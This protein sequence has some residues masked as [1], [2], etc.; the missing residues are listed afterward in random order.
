L[1][2]FYYCTTNSCA[3]YTEEN[4]ADK[5]RRN[6][7]YNEI[8]RKNERIKELHIFTTPLNYLAEEN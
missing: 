1:S 2:I 5:I 4:V 7:T 3:A 6:K 8:K